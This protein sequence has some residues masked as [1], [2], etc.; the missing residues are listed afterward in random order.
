MAQSGLQVGL[1]HLIVQPKQ[2]TITCGKTRVQAMS[3]RPPTGV[4]AGGG[5]R[6]ERVVFFSFF[7]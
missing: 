1:F 2:S 3:K 7:L 6:C 5:L 4:S